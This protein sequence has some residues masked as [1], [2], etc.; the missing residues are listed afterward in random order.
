MSGIKKRWWDPDSEIED[1]GTR[2][3]HNLPQCKVGDLVVF[4]RRTHSPN[5]RLMLVVEVYPKKPCRAHPCQNVIC[6]DILD[7][8]EGTFGADKLEVISEC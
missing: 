7:G 1:D 6:M 4:K 2:W 8:D 3:W 5:A